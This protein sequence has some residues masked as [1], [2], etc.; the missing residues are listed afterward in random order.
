A[1]VPMKINCGDMEFIDTPALDLADMGAK[2][3]KSKERSGTSCPNAQEWLDAY[4]GGDCVFAVTIT[5]TLSGSYSAARQ[6]KADYEEAHPGARVHVINSLSA[7]PEMEMILYKLRDLIDEGKDFDTIKAEITEYQ[8]HTRLGFALLCMDNLARNGRVSKA[9]AKIAGVLNIR[10]VGKASN[11]GT[12]EP[13]HKA[14]GEAKMQDALMTVL[15]DEGY[16]GGWVLIR[17]AGNAESA[18]T[19]RRCIKKKFPRAR[20]D[21]DTCAALCTYY[22]ETGGMLVGF[23]I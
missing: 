19:L 10:V 21:I 11:E 5:G 16:N 20:V 3:K 22:A 1:Y 14:R 9:V 2:L 15:A 17:H 8:K 6:A 12:L 4:E 23:E 18:E 7:G 13:L